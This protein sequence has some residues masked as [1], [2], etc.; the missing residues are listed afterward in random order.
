MKVKC[1][2][3]PAEKW[4]R[5]TFADNYIFCKVMETNSD[6]CKKNVGDAFGH[7]NRQNQNSG[8]RTDDKS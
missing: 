2:L 8:N 1:K 5:L 7:Q 4:K 3:S 6:V